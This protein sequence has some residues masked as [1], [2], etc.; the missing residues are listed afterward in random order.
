[1]ACS[2]VERLQGKYSIQVEHRDLLLRESRTEESEAVRSFK[3]RVYQSR[4]LPFYEKEALI[5]GRP[6]MHVRFLV[7][8]K[9]QIQGMVALFFAP[10]DGEES[11]FE[12]HRRDLSVED[13]SAMDAIIAELRADDSDDRSPVEVSQWMTAPGLADRSVGPLL[14]LLPSAYL[15]ECG[16]RYAACAAN[17]T[18]GAADQLVRLGGHYLA[19]RGRRLAFYSNRYRSEL[20]MVGFHS[21]DPIPPRLESE[22]IALRLL[23]RDEFL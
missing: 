1:M 19:C 12:E 3:R 11:L 17:V 2:L 14:A 4:E 20:S 18:N 8:L 13:Q 16:G 21:S 6:G 23:I 10:A 5:D 7:S 9:E 22:R 15:E